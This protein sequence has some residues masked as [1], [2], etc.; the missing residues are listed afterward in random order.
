ML[1]VIIAAQNE[2]LDSLERTVQTLR[3]TQSAQHEI[4]LMDDASELDYSRIAKRYDCILRKKTARTGQPPLIDEAAVLAK[5]E[6]LYICDAHMSF[7]DNGWDVEMEDV[8]SDEPNA[9]TCHVSKGFDNNGS[10]RGARVVA[11]SVGWF[12]PKWASFSSK[13]VQCPL[14]ASYGIRKPFYN[15][16]G[17]LKGIGFYGCNEAF[18][19]A[20]IYGVGGTV[21]M[22]DSYVRHNYAKRPSTEREDR[23]RGVSLA[24]N[25]ATIYWLLFEGL[26]ERPEAIL[27]PAYDQIDKKALAGLKD[28]LASV[29]SKKR[30]LAWLRGDYSP[31]G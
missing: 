18:W 9:M 4:I 23:R 16:I 8:L 21:R 29:V 27:Q 14:G 6:N 26:I 5:G 10:G 11:E 31:L 17:G 3:N 25:K 12:D 28:Y 2:P 13:I 7:E 22:L 19:A 1:S 24:L 20:K 30:L 15:Y